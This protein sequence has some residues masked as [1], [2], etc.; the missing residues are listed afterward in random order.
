MSSEAQ[1]LVFSDSPDE[2]ERIAQTIRQ[3]SD[4]TVRTVTNPATALKVVEALLP[5]IVF[6]H[7][8]AGTAAATRF[9]NEVWTRNPQTARFLLGDSTP[10]SEALINCV[11]SRIEVITG[12]ISG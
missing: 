8:H 5:E 10:D 2:G 11:F 3:I 12:E 6:A 4:R 7:S 1:I 9:L